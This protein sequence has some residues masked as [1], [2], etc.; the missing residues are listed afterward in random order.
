[1]ADTEIL[2]CGLNSRT[3]YQSI[4]FV[5]LHNVLEILLT[6]LL[7]DCLKPFLF[8]KNPCE[9]GFK[10]RPSGPL[11]HSALVFLWD[12]RIGLLKVIGLFSSK[13]FS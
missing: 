8:D 3:R 9:A 10:P 2:V 4:L 1:M 12:S 7:T 6:L 5:A 11:D 13:F